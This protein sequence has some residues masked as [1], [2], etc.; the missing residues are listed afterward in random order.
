MVICGMTGALTKTTWREKLSKDSLAAFK[1]FV[2]LSLATEVGG[3]M[4]TLYK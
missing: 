4:K 3:Q 1:P 2:A